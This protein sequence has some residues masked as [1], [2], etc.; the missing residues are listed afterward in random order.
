METSISTKTTI[1]AQ[2]ART[3]STVA[4]ILARV[5]MEIRIVVELYQVANNSINSNKD[6]KSNLL[7]AKRVTASQDR[8]L[9]AHRAFLFTSNNSR[10]R[11]RLT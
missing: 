9:G 4:T 11:P 10:L 3:A 2:I 6:A 1:S 5:A 7:S 8:L